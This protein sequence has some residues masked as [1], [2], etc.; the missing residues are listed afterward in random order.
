MNPLNGMSSWTGASKRFI[1]E[2]KHSVFMLV[3]WN[4]RD[5]RVIWAFFDP[6][7]ISISI[8]ERKQLQAWSA[9]FFI[10]WHQIIVT[11]PK[12][13]GSAL[14]QR[15]FLVRHRFDLEKHG[16]PFKRIDDDADCSTSAG[17]LCFETFGTSALDGTQH[18]C[19]PNMDKGY[20]RHHV[21]STSEENVS[22]FL[23]AS[24]SSSSSLRL[25]Y[26]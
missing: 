6:F 1:T 7:L 10:I 20:R 5:S 16:N 14:M 18:G 23:I 2:H 9:S 17:A 8:S 4:M 25:T 21:K 3:R 22:I 24:F 19:Y 12:V 11:G 13:K 15:S 26:K